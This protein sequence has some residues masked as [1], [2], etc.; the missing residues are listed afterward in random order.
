[1]RQR[2]ALTRET[3]PSALGLVT[4][5]PDR[6]DLPLACNLGPHDGPARLRRWQHLA[7]TANPIAVRDGPQLKVRYEPVPGVHEELEALAAAE[8]ECCSFVSWSVA[9]DGAA[10][11]LLVTADPDTP[12]AVEP[13]AA[14]FGAS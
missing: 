4:D 14:L 13:I 6:V 2:A 7:D 8:A 5:S 9:Q 3:R 10:P 12:D 11:L 1:M